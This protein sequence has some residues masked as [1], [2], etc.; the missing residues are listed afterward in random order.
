MSIPG[1]S[2]FNIILL[3]LYADIISIMACTKTCPLKDPVPEY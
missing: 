1:K 3:D 2:S